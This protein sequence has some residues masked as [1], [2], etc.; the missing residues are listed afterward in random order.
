MCWIAHKEMT[1]ESTILTSN[2]SWHVARIVGYSGVY[3]V[4]SVEFVE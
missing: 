3:S 2:S 4:G 1:D